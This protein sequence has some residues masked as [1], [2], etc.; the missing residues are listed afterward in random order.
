M[1]YTS[2]LTKFL[3]NIAM[4]GLTGGVAFAAATA[5]DTAAN[6]A[7]SWGTSP[8]NLGSGFDAWA[9]QVINGNN[10]PYAGTYLDLTSY[11]NSD[12]VLSSGYSWG[13][14]A[15]GSPGNGEFILARGFTAGPSGSTSLYNHTFSIGIGSAGV[16]GTGSSIGLSVGTAFSLSYIG[17]TSDN[18]WLSVDGGAATAVPVTY[19]NLNAGLNVALAVSGALNSTS[20]GYTLT[21]SPFAGGPAIYTTS[22][23]FDSSAY[24]TSGFSINDLNT[25]NDAFVNNPNIT[26]EVV[27]EPATLA[28]CA[29]SGLAAL[30]VV[31]RRN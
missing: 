10:P 28:L 24:N 12:G 31:R 22:G 6:Y 13:T 7:S 2:V 25:S 21:L 29:L 14:Y 19:A 23:T 1:K 16:G 15:N 3:A 30:L 27:P 9:N 17:G 20:E 4:L 26:A 11:G 5:T 8:P 18:F